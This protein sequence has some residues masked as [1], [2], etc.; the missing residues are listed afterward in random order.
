MP[1]KALVAGGAVGDAIAAVGG[2]AARLAVLHSG[3][4][5]P[6]V[7][8]AAWVALSTEAA[9]AAGAAV[10]RVA[11]S[12]R[13]RLPGSSAHHRRR[14]ELANLAAPRGQD[15]TERLALP[16]TRLDHICQKV[17]GGAAPVVRRSEPVDA[18]HGT[19]GLEKGVDRF[20]RWQLRGGR[21][22]AEVGPVGHVKGTATKQLWCVELRNDIARAVTAALGC[23]GRLVPRPAVPECCSLRW[24]R[25]AQAG[26]GDA[27][28]ATWLGRS[29]HYVPCVCN[30]A[31]AWV[32]SHKSACGRAAAPALPPET[33]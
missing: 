8:A 5:V 4:V 22:P 21:R 26:L 7:P 24:L 12:V 2:G 29:F 32:A 9:G 19:P 17:S 13:R 31:E 30:A 6:S 33:P 10:S 18:L 1:Q 25:A 3:L 23:A 20:E 28:R 15:G 11:V 14:A 27:G 16:R